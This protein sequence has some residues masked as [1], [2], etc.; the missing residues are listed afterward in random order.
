MMQVYA[1]VAGL[2]RR[3]MIVLPFLTPTIASL[4]VGTVTP[5]PLR[6]GATAGR[7][8]GMR[9][10]DANS[11]SSHHQ[12]T[13]DGLTGYRARS[14]ACTAR[15]RPP[16]T[17]ASLG[18]SR[19]RRCPA[20]PIGPARSSTPTC[21]RRRRPPTPKPSGRRLSK[22]PRAAAGDA[23]LLPL[24]EKRSR[25]EVAAALDG[26]VTGPGVAGNHG[27][28]YARAVAAATRNGRSS[29]RAASGDGCT[30]WWCGRC[31]SPRCAPWHATSSRRP[32]TGESDAEQRR[33][34]QHH[35]QA[36][37]E[38]G[39]HRCQHP[40][41]GPAL[42]RTYRPQETA[43]KPSIGLPLAMVAAVYRRVEISTGCSR[44]NAVYSAPRKNSSSA[45]PLIKV[46]NTISRKDPVDC[47]LQHPEDR[48]GDRRNLLSDQSAQ[49]EEAADRQA[50]GQP[51]MTGRWLRPRQ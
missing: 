24:G 17:W 19:P 50:D 10:G 28:T 36:P 45:T 33:Q 9:C 12:T 14:A 41:A 11:T 5:I 21:R 6:A 48:G 46:I 30:G 51:E 15:R 16:A 3:Y 42:Q 49:H 29:C 23:C 7:I 47:E 20:I 37:H 18:P 40:A 2:G 26:A 39:Q 25:R 27:A 31:V 22:L 44:P 35:D 8:A 34:G 32:A 4:W 13:T 38:V 43:A 1:E